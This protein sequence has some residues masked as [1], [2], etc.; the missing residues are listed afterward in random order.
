ML[1]CTQEMVLCAGKTVILMD[2]FIIKELKLLISGTIGTTCTIGM[3]K[4][5]EL[6]VWIV[7][8]LVVLRTHCSLMIVVMVLVLMSK[9]LLT[10]GSHKL[11]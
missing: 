4:P 5:L 8:I 9:L 6:I 2:Y 10:S 7:M 1:F 3:T 11:T